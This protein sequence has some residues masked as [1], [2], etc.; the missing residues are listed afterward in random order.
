MS[1]NTKKWLNRVGVG[2]VVLG[3]VGIVAGGGNV[4]TALS[5][6]SI[7]AAGVG[8]A[9]ALIKEVIQSIAG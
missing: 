8:A 6:G 7:V 2:L 5:L 4:E 9:I 3:V 1:D